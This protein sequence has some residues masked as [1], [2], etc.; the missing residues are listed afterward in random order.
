[1]KELGLPAFEVVIIGVLTVV[2]LIMFRRGIVGL[3]T[4]MYRSVL[5]KIRPAASLRSENRVVPSADFP[6]KTESPAVETSR[7]SDP[8]DDNEADILY[9][10]GVTKNF[11]SLKAVDDVS[12][13]LQRGSITSLIGPNG[14]GKTTVFNVISGHLPLTAGSIDFDGESIDKLH[15]Y[16][17][18]RRGVARTFQN[19]RLYPNLT[20]LQ[21]VMCGR[22]RLSKQS[23]PALLL[24]TR[25]VARD[26][27]DLL[28]AAHHYLGFVGL[29]KY[30]GA[31][32]DE[33]SFG[34]QRLVEI[35]RALALDPILILMD[36]PASGLNDAETEVLA[37]LLFKIRQNGTTIFLVEHDIRLIMGVSDYVEVMHSGKKL[38]SGRTEEVRKDPKVVAAYLGGNV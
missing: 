18:A 23:L 2:V 4:D 1:L 5:E 15:P 28:C 21:N 35:A 29:E 36:E 34:H 27:A 31:M 20:V 13:R 14:A 10:D 16:Q 33:L 24:H 9:L 8:K 17:I 32:P 12:F 19:L 6:G 25:G 11:G 37:E 30:A 26:E 3:F 38:A 22:H 7:N